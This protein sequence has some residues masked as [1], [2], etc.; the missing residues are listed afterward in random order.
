MS[1]QKQKPTKAQQITELKEQ[2]S[3]QEKLLARSK[4]NL[5]TSEKLR[6]LSNKLVTIKKENSKIN[7]ETKRAEYESMQEY[8]D[9]SI[10]IMSVDYYERKEPALKI[11]EIKLKGDI[12]GIERAMIDITEE[13]VKLGDREVVGDSNE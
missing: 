1:R 11:E 5:S 10:E 13:L 3:Y 9:I 12:S 6:D 7:P 2:L 8:I 4:D